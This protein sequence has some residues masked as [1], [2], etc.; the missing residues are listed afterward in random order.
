ADPTI[1]AYHH[2][3][4]EKPEAS[5]I[6]RYP[7]IA[8]ITSLPLKNP[9]VGHLDLQNNAATAKINQPSLFDPTP[10]V[11]ARMVN[12]VGTFVEIPSLTV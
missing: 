7:A 5:L 1:G 10:A 4:G 8:A 11:Q 12:G 2:Y 6:T 3:N 9:Y